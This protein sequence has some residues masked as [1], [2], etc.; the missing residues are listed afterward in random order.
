MSQ[1]SDASIKNQE[2]T[3]SLTKNSDTLQQLEG[4]QYATSLDMNIGYDHLKLTPEAFEMCNIVTE[5]G[6]YNYK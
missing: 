3:V 5:F 1:I 4:F 6:K 2:K